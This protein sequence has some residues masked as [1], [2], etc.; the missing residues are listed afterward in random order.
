VLRLVP[1]PIRPGAYRL[2]LWI[3]GRQTD[4]GHGRVRQVKLHYE[5]S[6]KDVPE[7]DAHEGVGRALYARPVFRL[8]PPARA[9]AEYFVSIFWFLQSGFSRLPGSMRAMPPKG[10]KRSNKGS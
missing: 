6:E 10:E 5:C 3:S 7:Q 1:L 9:P 4:D 2:V 8:E